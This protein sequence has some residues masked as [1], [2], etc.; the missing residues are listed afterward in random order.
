M[1]TRR[2]VITQVLTLVLAG[3]L[4][5]PAA[6]SYAQDSRAYGAVIFMHRHVPASGHYK[7]FD[8][9]GTFKSGTDIMWVDWNADG[10]WDECFGIAPDR[11][12]WHEWRNSGGWREMPNHGHADDMAG[13]EIDSAGRHRVTDKVNGHGLY[14]SWLTPSGWQGWHGC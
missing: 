13:A 1:R 12:I 4:L 3:L 8:S 10:T 11:T 9:E 2:A 5:G 7:C 6:L 14:C